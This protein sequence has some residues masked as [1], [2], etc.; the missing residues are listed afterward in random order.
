MR[1]M[2]ICVFNFASVASLNPKSSE[3]KQVMGKTRQAKHIPLREDINWRNPRDRVTTDIRQ[4]TPTLGQVGV[5]HRA[6]SATMTHETRQL[7]ATGRRW[8]TQQE[9]AKAIKTL[10]NG[11]LIR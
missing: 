9:P 1:Q 10:K 2:R 4:E 11:N 3:M 6:T 8:L 7:R 5:P